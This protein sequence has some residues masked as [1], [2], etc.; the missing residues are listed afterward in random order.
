[1]AIV[2]AVQDDFSGGSVCVEDK[3]EKWIQWSVALS[4]WSYTAGIGLT[5]LCPGLS[6]AFLTLVWAI[7]FGTVFAIAQQTDSAFEFEGAGL[8]LVFC[9]CV[10][11]TLDGE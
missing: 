9:A 3:G 2:V 8:L 7:A 4:Q 6:M 10:V 11:R 1:M 5:I